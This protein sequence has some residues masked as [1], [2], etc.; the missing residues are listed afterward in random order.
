MASQADA[1]ACVYAMRNIL[2]VLRKVLPLETRS[3]TPGLVPADP[4]GSGRG[5]AYRRLF[6]AEIAQQQLDDMVRGRW[7]KL[8]NEGPALGDL[9]RR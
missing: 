3:G 6:A 8:D 1:G 5:M 2:W 7:G 4:V 9:L